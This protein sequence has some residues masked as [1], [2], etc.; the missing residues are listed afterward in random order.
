MNDGPLAR[1]MHEMVQRIRE[2]LGLDRW[3]ITVEC[4]TGEQ[5]GACAASPE[6]REA[7]IVFDLERFET[8]DEPAE[9]VAHECAHPH[10]WPLHALAESLA[11]ALASSAPEAMREPMR[12]LLQEQVRL[13][14][15]TVT[16]DVGHTYLRLLR[17]AGIL[18]TPT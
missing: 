5:R 7:T 8:G 1:D 12:V 15:E 4:V 3:N 14:A 17:R 2:P 10:I 11:D 18:E 16:T 9:M 6:Y 13:A